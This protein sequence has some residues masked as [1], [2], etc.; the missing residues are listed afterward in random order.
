VSAPAVTPT[1]SH[2]LELRRQL[3]FA[4]EGFELLDQKRQTLALELV[5][6]AE[7]LRQAEEDVARRLAPAEAALREATLDAGTAALDRA[8]LGA[9]P[10]HEVV[11][12]AQRFMGLPLP[13]VR[14]EL[15]PLRPAFGPTGTSPAADLARRG[16]AEILPALGALAERQTAVLRLSRELRRAQRRCNALTR[17][18]IPQCRRAIH[19]IAGTLE[20]REREFFVSRRFAGRTR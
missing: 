1:K 8:A 18:V 17:I 16:F 15:R 12:S 11:L 5:R 6:R 9:T 13:L 3:A 4:L 14:V 2:L 7:L 10:A 20:E 19:D